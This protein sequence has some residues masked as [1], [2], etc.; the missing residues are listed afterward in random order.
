MTTTGT[1]AL[2]T[3]LT[4]HRLLDDGVA[5]RAGSL[6]G[7][8]DAGAPYEPALAELV[9]YLA[10]EVLPHALAEEHTLYRVAGTRAGLAGSVGEMTAEHRSLAEAVDDL[11]DAPS[12]DVAIVRA[13]ALAELFAAHVAKENDVILPA[14]ADDD[15]V[16]LAQLLVQMHRLVETARLE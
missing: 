1:E 2:E 4:H 3:M 16:D 10:H 14:L 13:T 5:R 8:V 12:A 15:E 11:A 7:A 9:A 6:R